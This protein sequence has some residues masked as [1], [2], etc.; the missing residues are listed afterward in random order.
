MIGWGGS[1]VKRGESGLHAGSVLSPLSAGDSAA[2]GGDGASTTRRQSAMRA[3]LAGAALWAA[4]AAATGDILRKTHTPFRTTHSQRSSK[5]PE[6]SRA[7][8][9]PPSGSRTTPNP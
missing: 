5:K 1:M 4:A 6:V 2:S 3:S 8:V 9:K 7:V